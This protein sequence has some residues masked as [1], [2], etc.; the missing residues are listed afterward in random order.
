MKFF[1]FLISEFPAGK[2]RKLYNVSSNHLKQ[3]VKSHKHECTLVYE[4]RLT[5]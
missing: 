1:S 5:V 4:L 3:H 2:S